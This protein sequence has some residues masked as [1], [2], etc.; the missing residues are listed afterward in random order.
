MAFHDTRLPVDVERGALGGPG[1]MTDIS[2]LGSGKEQRNIEWARIRAEFD[3]GYGL[4]D[5]DSVILEATIDSLLAF[6]YTRE[7]RAHS[8]RFKDWSDFRIGDWE[9][10]TVVNQSIGTGDASEDTFTI[11]KRYVDGAFFYDRP[12]THLVVGRVVVLVDNVVQTITTDYTINYLTG[13][14]IF[15]GGSIPG[16]GAD[17]QVALEFD[18]PVRFDT[19]KLQLNL[20]MFQRGS[21]ENIPIVEE[22]Q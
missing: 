21:W 12:I 13:T 16:A 1:F 6:F 7:G 20:T 11:F 8:F 17:V 22:K 3:I 5:Q 2:P 4:M 15:T 14:I 18:I 19:D 9:N 10:P